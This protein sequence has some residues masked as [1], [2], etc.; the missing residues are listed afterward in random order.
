MAEANRTLT[1]STVE[2][3]ITP[4]IERDYR[5]RGVFPTLRIENTS[6]FWNS[7]TG[8]YAVSPKDAEEILKD[9]EVQQSKGSELPRGT[10][11]AY[12]SLVEKLAPAVKRAKGLWDDPGREVVVE[13]SQQDLAHFLPGQKAK[14]WSPF[15]D[16]GYDGETV[17]IVGGYSFR[18]VAVDPENDALKNYGHYIDEKD[19]LVCYR[20]GYSVKFASKEHL[21]FLPPYM[22]QTLDDKCSYLRL[23]CGHDKASPDLTF[24]LAPL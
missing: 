16:G 5:R 11:K 13:R 24:T 18:R 7:A 20:W 12:S 10:P 8:I 19:G 4:T 1:A 22:L 14:Y 21:I 23:V 2:V 3:R 6:R 9:A 17:E 15:V